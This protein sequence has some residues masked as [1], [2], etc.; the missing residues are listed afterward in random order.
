MTSALRHETPVVILKMVRDPLQHGG[1]GIARSLG[2]LGVAV[3]TAYVD[4]WSAAGTSRYVRSRQVL[5]RPN[6]AE[7]TVNAL[8]ARAR[9][10]RRRPILIPADDVACLFVDEH[11]DA[12]RAEYLLP[13]QPPGL[14][15]ELAH[16]GALH[17]VAERHG[18]PVPA[19]AFPSDLAEAESAAERLGY[20]V[21]A[22]SMDPRV[23]RQRPKSRSVAIAEDRD[24][25]RRIVGDDLEAGSLNLMLQEFLPG[26]PETVWMF[27]GYVDRSGQCDVAFTGRKLRQ[28]PPDTGATSLGLCV[29]N[30][31]V[32][33]TAR[34]FLAG[35]GYRGIVDMGLRHDARDG[36]YKL[37]DVNPRI[38]SSFRLF[39]GAS[40]VD[41]ARALYLDLTDQPAAAPSLAEDG[42]RWLVENQ[43]LPTSWHLMRRGDLTLPGWLSS[44]RG[45]REGAWFAWDDP[46]PTMAM[47]AGTWLDALRQVRPRLT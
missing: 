43:D 42:R 15:F 10:L 21:V 18:I 16:K 13:P 45:V 20:P 7:A 33:E 29:W 6:E 46:L 47:I 1:L 11:G 41:V 19:A 3:H 32:A 8:V 26:G 36:T 27:N 12:L 17:R 4:R 23:L 9:G 34:R 25:L 35:V 22:K 14:P 39:V 40:G 2:R 24:E 31:D 5:S 38:G 44:F 37:L 30:P 28:A